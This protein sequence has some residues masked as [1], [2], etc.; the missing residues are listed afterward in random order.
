MGVSVL[1]WF[2]TE[3]IDE[4]TYAI[5]E[6]NHWEKVHSY[7][8]LG[9]ETAVLIDTGLGIGDI[10]KEVSQITNLPVKV[11]TT[12]VHWDHIG[13]H[14]AFDK[15]YVHRGDLKWF[16][17]G[18]PIPI[19]NVRDNVM[20]GVDKK[21]LPKEFNID[22]YKIFRGEPTG[23]LE[24]NDIIDLG[25]RKVR[26]IHAPGHS[27]GHICVWEEEK[28]YLFSGD[29]IY[30]G[31]LFAFYPSTNPKLFMESIDKVRRIEGIQK[32]FPSHNEIDITND[33]IER[34][35]IAFKEIEEKNRLHHGGGF[36]EY[37]DFNIKI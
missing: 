5:S 7:L 28:G 29:L 20:Y 32:V 15:V 17:E 27:P 8:L 25:G 3:K 9:D 23:I 13:G 22:E 10:K 6:Y 31:T 35:H 36:F 18:L 34:I 12:H 26:I 2:I 16:Q 21:M 14:A 30:K 11:L 37:K 33:I 24:D 1:K 4:R 19:A